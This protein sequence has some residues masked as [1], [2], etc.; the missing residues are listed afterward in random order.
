M[1]AYPLSSR[2][3]CEDVVILKLDL[4]EAGRALLRVVGEARTISCFRSFCSTGIGVDR[5]S[6]RHDEDVAEVAVSCAAQVSMAEAYYGLVAMLIACAVL[7]DFALIA[8][9]NIMWNGVCLRTQLHNAKRDA[10]SGESVPHTVRADNGI[11][12]VNDT[13]VGRNRQAEA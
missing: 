12:I 3:L 8:A 5:T 7:I 2:E 4:I 10:G 13:F 11:D 1:Y 9:V 6:R